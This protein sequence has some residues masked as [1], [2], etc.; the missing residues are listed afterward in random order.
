[1]LSFGSV[2]FFRGFLVCSQSGLRP[3]EDEEKMAIIFRK[4]ELNMAINQI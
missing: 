3:W 1:M 4:I 2:S